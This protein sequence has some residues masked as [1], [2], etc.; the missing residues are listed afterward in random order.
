[1]DISL[2]KGIIKS[3]VMD[4]SNKSYNKIK[5]EK[6]NGRVNIIELENIIKEYGKTIIPLPEEAFNIANIYNIEREDRMNIYIPL[7]TKEEGRSDLTLSLICHLKNNK[8][9]IEI[10]DLEV[11]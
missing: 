3:L 5:K 4:L 11:L 10:N 6:I 1:M 9:T 7:W 8:P 2:F